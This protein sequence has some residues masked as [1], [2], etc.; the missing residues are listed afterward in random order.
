MV[1]ADGSGSNTLPPLIE[2]REA[3]MTHLEHHYLRELMTLAADMQEACTISGLSRSRL[4]ALL[5]KHNLP[6]CF[7]LPSWISP[8]ILPGKT[9]S[10]PARSCLAKQ[11]HFSRHTLYSRFFLRLQRHSV[12]AKALPTTQKAYTSTTSTIRNFTDYKHCSLQ[13]QDSSTPH[14]VAAF[15]IF[16]SDM[17]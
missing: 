6:S 16:R 12:A 14:V 5:K 3:A 13:S 2:A 10:C 7:R 9:H 15:L 1:R 4:Y 17:E 11:D 8:T